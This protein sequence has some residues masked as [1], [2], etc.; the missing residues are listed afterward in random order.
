[1]SDRQFPLFHQALL[2]LGPNDQARAR[3]L[4]I[5][6]RTLM[7]YKRGALPRSLETTPPEVLRALADDKE[8]QQSDQ[9]PA[10][11]GQTAEATA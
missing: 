7:D 8:R 6:R 5:A 10:A 9:E 3:R 4:G 2:A 11:T 1:M